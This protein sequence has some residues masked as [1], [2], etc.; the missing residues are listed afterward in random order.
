[1][2]VFFQSKKVLERPFCLLELYIAATKG[3]PIVALNCTG[4]GYNFNAAAGFLAHLDIALPLVSKDAVAVLEQN[5]IDL[6]QAAHALSSAIPNIISIPFNTSASRTAIDAT[7]IDLAKA[8]MAAKPHTT[9]TTLWEF[10]EQRQEKDAE[11][12]ARAKRTSLGLGTVRG[13]QKGV[14]IQQARNAVSLESQLGDLKAAH[15]V[16]VAKLEAEAT[17]LKAALKERDAEQKT[18]RER[19]EAERE[20]HA[21][22]LA[23]LRVKLETKIEKLEAKLGY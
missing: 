19:R 9:T 11:S 17:E 16:E 21:A 18:E 1:M 20:E 8:C 13:T 22:S 15:K 3:T 23:S 14:L 12:A 2:L 5:G 6:K 4:K 7:M 10:L